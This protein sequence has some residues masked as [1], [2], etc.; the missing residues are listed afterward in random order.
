MVSPKDVRRWLDDNAI[1]DDDKQVNVNSFESGAW[2]VPDDKRDE[3]LHLYASVYNAQKLQFL[4]AAVPNDTWNVYP[5]MD[6]DFDRIEDFKIL[7]AREN[8]DHWAFYDRVAEAFGQ[9]I[10]MVPS[11]IRSGITFCRKPGETNI[12][13]FH[14]VCHNRQ[15]IMTKSDM[16]EKVI[17]AAKLLAERFNLSE[18]TEKMKKKK[19]D[20]QFE[21]KDWCVGEH[22]NSEV[23]DRAAFV[24]LKALGIRPVGAGKTPSWKLKPN[25]DP[26]T[27]ATTYQIYD[28]QTKERQFKVTPQ[29]LQPHFLC[30]PGNDGRRVER[31]RTSRMTFNSANLTDVYSFPFLASFKFD[32]NAD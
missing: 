8:I 30:A 2:Y 1:K 3:F 28:L 16:K 27:W 20:G 5:Y 9:A 24:D 14:L 22:T 32:T 4:N 12:H 18:I 26:D 25:Q 19:T 15:F 23:K 11:Q 29:Q 31:S 6:V 17:N 10:G 7:L 13:R 21:D